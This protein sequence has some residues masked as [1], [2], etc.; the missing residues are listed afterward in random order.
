[1][2]VSR[3]IAPTDTS[4]FVRAFTLFDAGRHTGGTTVLAWVDDQ[5]R[6]LLRE[7]VCADGGSGGELYA[8]PASTISSVQV[9]DH[10]EGQPVRIDASATG[11]GGFILVGQS[12]ALRSIVDDLRTAAARLA[13]AEARRP[14]E[15]GLL[16]LIRRAF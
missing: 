12:A 5:A 10:D 15:R 6:L 8:L 11:T 13:E 1:M 9:F 7:P 16:R 2:A 3:N 4:G 14:R